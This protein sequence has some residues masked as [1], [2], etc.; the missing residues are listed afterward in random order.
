M[1]PPT[2]LFNITRLKPVSRLASDN[3]NTYRG[4]THIRL[5]LYKFRCRTYTM[6]LSSAVKKFN[7]MQIANQFNLA[8]LNVAK[9][10]RKS[11]NLIQISLT[12]K[13]CFSS[14]TEMKK[15]YL[16]LNPLVR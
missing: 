14:I 7:R 8:T 10:V 1:K 15:N 12:R 16:Q 9:L 5:V 13:A 11:K 6:V 2:V 3:G 4:N